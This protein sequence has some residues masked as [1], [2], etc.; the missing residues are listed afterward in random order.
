M[1]LEAKGVLRAAALMGVGA[2]SLIAL[3]VSALAQPEAGAPAGAAPAQSLVPASAPTASDRGEMLQQYC[4][5]CHNDKARTAG[6]SVVGLDASDLGK[7]NDVWEKILRKVSAGEMPPRNMRRPSPEQ[8]SEFTHWLETSLDGYAAKHLNPGRASVRRLNRAEYA[9]AV[10]DLLDFDVDM[11][12]ELPGDDAGYGFDNIADALTF[13]PTQMQRYL[14]VAGKVARLSTGHASDKASITTYKVPKDVSK[15]YWGVPAYNERSNDALP[16]DSR[17]GGAFDYYAPYDA[18]YRITV[19]L[20]NNSGWELDL[21][22]RHEYSTTVKLTAGLHSLG[23]AFAKSTALKEVANRRYQVPGNTKLQLN[24]IPP[25]PPGLIPMTFYVDGANAE[26]IPVPEYVNDAAYWQHNFP[27]DVLQVQVTGPIDVSGKGDTPARRRIFS[28]QPGS[29]EASETACAKKVLTRLATRAYRRTATAADLAPLM[30]VYAKGR[31][32]GGFERGIQYGVEAVLVSPNFLFISD[33]GAPNST[34]QKL[35]PASGREL[36]TRLSFFLWSSLPDDELVKLGQQGKLRDRKVLE[37]QVKRMLADPR[38]IALT[39]NFAGQWLYIRNMD[40]QAPNIDQFPNFDER[41]R[42][43]M[44]TET[45]MFF[46]SVVRE[47][48]SVLT[49][50]DADYTFLNERL[51][52][53]YGIPGVKGTTFRRVTLDPKWHRGGLLGKASLL[54]V[55]SYDNR[56][57]IVRRGKWILENL[58]VSPPPPPPPNVPALAEVPAGKKLTVR[59]QTEL[60]RANPVCSSCHNL[61]DPLGFALDNYD[62]VGA[63]RDEEAGKPVD[64]AGVMANG[65]AFVG[66]KGL[67]DVL[68]SRKEQFVDAFVEKLMTYALARGVEGHD[69]PMVREIRR[70]AERDNYAFGSIVLGIVESLPFQMQGTVPEP[71]PATPPR[72]VATNVSANSVPTRNEPTRGEAR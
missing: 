37:Q 16:L 39:K 43:A 63:W 6:M 50:I 29:S 51:A 42:A 19:T 22:K 56:T 40:V 32:E 48:R 26:T 59:E 34:P 15:D 9:N 67:Q 54:T 44:K 46:D 36:A 65:Q 64:V 31:A 5:S 35:R 53:H 60:H 33:I 18:T 38:A 20:N 8:L 45:E 14:V 2:V 55:T 70:N 41:L 21:E 62:A 71:S 61:M 7:S 47:N 57:S 49:F 1:S 17:G 23:A 12:Q 58:L 66:V 11:S 10:R 69:M 24:F 4:S 68:M 28:C 3:G 30:K 72:Q 13:S 27:R 52:D 25:P